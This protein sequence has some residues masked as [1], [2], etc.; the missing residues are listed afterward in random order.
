MCIQSIYEKSNYELVEQKTITRENSRD[1]DLN[2]FAEQNPIFD[3]IGVTDLNYQMLLFDY[4]VKH[5]RY[6]DFKN[7]LHILISI[8]TVCYMFYILLSMQPILV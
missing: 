3:I 2:H 6:D 8:I 5:K 7:C 4:Y 1:I